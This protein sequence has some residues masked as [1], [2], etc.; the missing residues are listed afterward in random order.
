MTD[1]LT[2]KASSSPSPTRHAVKQGLVAVGFE[3]GHMP[4]EK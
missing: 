3:D 4:R 1:A 2:K